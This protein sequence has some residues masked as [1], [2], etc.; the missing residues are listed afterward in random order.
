MRLP[1]YKRR[2]YAVTTEQEAETI[3]YVQKV[4]GLPETGELDEGT[5]SHIRG[6]QV[7]FGLRATGIVDDATAELVERI[8][9]YGA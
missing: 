9:P 7:L 5:Q 2:V 4:L 1:W 6:L 8:W 3:R